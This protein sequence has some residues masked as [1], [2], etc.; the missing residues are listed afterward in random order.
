[1]RQEKARRDKYGGK[2]FEIVRRH[3]EF[4]NNRNDDTVD[5][6]PR[7]TEISQFLKL[8]VPKSTS[9]I[10][11]EAKPITMVPVPMPTSAKPLLCATRAPESATSA[12]L[13]SRP[14]MI[15]MSVLT[16]WALAI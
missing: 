16:P 11:T 2:E 6:G 12:L 8:L 1:M 5:N 14:R 9:P 3:T 7:T 4:Q 10:M 15:M 13:I